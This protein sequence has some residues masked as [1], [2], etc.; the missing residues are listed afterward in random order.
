M[1]KA[2]PDEAPPPNIQGQANLAQVLAIL[3][4][5]VANTL[6]PWLTQAGN[7]PQ[8][9]AWGPIIATVASA[10]IASHVLASGEEVQ[11]K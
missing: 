5:W 3:S 9:G 7:L 1:S 10:L 4:P 2:N 6:L 11:S 8:L